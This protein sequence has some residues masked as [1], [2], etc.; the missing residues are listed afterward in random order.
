MSSKH[1]VKR[2][3]KNRDSTGS[4]SNVL[5]RPISSQ[6]FAAWVE[7]FLV[8]TLGRGDIAIMDNLASHKGQ[9]I[10]RAI[11]AVGDRLLFLPPLFARPQCS[12]KLFEG[13]IEQ[14]FAKL[15]LLMGKPVERSVEDCWQCASAPCSTISHHRNAPPIFEARATLRRRWIRPQDARPTAEQ[16][17][18]P[19]TLSP[20]HSYSETIMAK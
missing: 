13:P 18:R 3:K 2:P 20:E 10:R 14:A 1:W 11:R 12:P 7:Q 9:A 17:A 15:R 6:S 5:N 16:G 8:P 19:S 4:V